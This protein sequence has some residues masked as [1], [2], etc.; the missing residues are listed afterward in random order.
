MK[1]ATLRFN[2]IEIAEDEIFYFEEGILGFNNQKRY[3]IIDT[4]KES[5]FKWFQSVDDP[6]LAFVVTDPLTFKSDYKI[7]ISEEDAKELKIYD[8]KKTKVYVI[9]SIPENPLEM[10][11]NLVGPLVFNPEAKLAKQIVLLNDSYDTKYKILKS[12]GNKLTC[13]Y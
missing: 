11:A 6:S 3:L 12:S 10:T 5:P 8:S 9:V 2:E 1:I 7:E 13:V 4:N